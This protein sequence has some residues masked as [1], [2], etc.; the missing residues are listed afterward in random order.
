MQQRV[1]QTSFRNVKLKQW[2][3]EV[4]SRTSSTLLSTNGESLCSHKGLISWIFT[5]SSWTTKQWIICHPKWQKSGQ[6]VLYVWMVFW[7]PV[8]S[9]MFVPQIIKIWRSFFNLQSIMSGILFWDT[10][11]IATFS[12]N[13]HC[14]QMFQAP[15]LS[16]KFHYNCWFLSKITTE[17]ELKSA[18][19]TGRQATL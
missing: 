12:S 4:W 16:S 5:V 13:L 14:L 6:N 10:M 8:V 3:V 1:Y 15:H 11:L 18:T 9:G 19:S 2:L 7:W 17:F